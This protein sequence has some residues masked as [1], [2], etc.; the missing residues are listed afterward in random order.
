MP[1]LL[2]GPECASICLEIGAVLDKPTYVAL[3][4]ISA[5]GQGLTHAVE[6]YVECETELPI[7][8]GAEIKKVPVEGQ[9]L[10]KPAPTSPDQ[11]AARSRVRIASSGVEKH[12]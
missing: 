2:G 11:V 5:M 8:G 3:Q 9:D 6:H 1:P 12:H 10:D 7:T 4:H